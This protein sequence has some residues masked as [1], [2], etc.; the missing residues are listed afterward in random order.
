[1]IIVLEPDL[2]DT[3]PV[4]QAIVA[5]AERYEGITTR[6]YRYSGAR[7]TFTEVHLIGSTGAVFTEP[8]ESLPGVR[9]VVRVSAKYRLIGRHLDDDSRAVGFE[10]NGVEFDDQNLHLFAGLC[11]VD[12]PDHVDQMMTALAK[13]G[14]VTT[15]MGAYK[16]R[17]SPYD[18]QEL[19]KKC[20]PYVFELAGR[21]GVKVIALEVTNARPE[22]ALCGGPQALRLEQ[23]PVLV[24]HAQRIRSTYKAASVACSGQSEDAAK[25]P[26]TSSS[27]ASWSSHA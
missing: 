1:M 27:R 22:A 7:H 16:P 11:A 6:P 5:I 8:F 20:L 9:R 17:T 24:D 15:R 18:F 12:T 23:L 13:E 10:Y 21:H 19:G 26:G 3:E 4:V 14:I 2:D 25:A